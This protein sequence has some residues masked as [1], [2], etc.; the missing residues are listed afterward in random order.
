MGWLLII[1]AIFWFA[2][3]SWFLLIIA[4]RL[5]KLHSRAEEI[6]E[7][8]RFIERMLGGIRENTQEIPSALSSLTVNSLEK[9]DNG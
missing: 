7:T 6:H 5:G 8:L 9:K 4:Q 3:V 2:G 1:P